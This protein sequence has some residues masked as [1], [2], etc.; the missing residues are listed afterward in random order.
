MIWEEQMIPQ[1]NRIEAAV[2][3]VALAD[4]SRAEALLDV[5]PGK[6]PLI[7]LSH[8]PPNYETPIDCFRNAIT[9]ND[10]FFVRYHLSGIPEI[11]AKRWKLTVDGDGARG[12]TE[13]SLGDLK[14]LPSVEVTA[15]N[16]CSGNRRRLW[17]P[18]VTGVQWG[19]GAMGCA[20]WKG[21]RLKDVLDKA[22]LRKDALE[23]VFNGA[24]GAAVDQTPDYLKSLPVWKAIEDTTLI[25]YEM[26]GVPLPHWHGF[27]A[28][29]IVPGWTG[30]YW[31]KHLTSIM[32]TT[33]PFD[34][35]WMKSAYRIPIGE[36]PVVARF[37][38]QETAVDTPITEMVVNSLITSPADGAWVKAGAPLAIG[39][40]AWDGGYGI[41]SVEV[42]TDGG[43]FWTDAALGKD[44]GK[45]AFRPWSYQF[46]PQA[47]GRHV[48]MARATNR[49]G[50]T[51]TSE[52]IQN[53]AGFHH[54]VV[55]ALTLI[56]T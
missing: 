47:R 12:R 1:L 40:L 29:L 45:Y 48:V 11:D 46:S 9:P 16:H 50:Q 56:A 44:F 6:K 53:P 32:A 43:R 26:N 15:V 31:V 23:I 54:N 33:K 41:R 10:T 20:R 5:L 4:V 42:S 25:A 36:F 55:Q 14:D 3:G 2:I 51:Q 28:R 30:T 34:G 37:I 19:Y 18:P 52:L 49:I 35:F 21:A 13:L 39:G 27:P 38:S 17:Q 7:R 22:G 24:D 8:Q